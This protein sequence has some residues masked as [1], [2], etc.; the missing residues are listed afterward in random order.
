MR[1]LYVGY[2]LTDDGAPHQGMAALHLA[3]S[4]VDVV[5]ASWS[6]DPAPCWIK[7]FP[8]LQYRTFRKR[9][10]LSALRL[11][12]SLVWLVCSERWDA[13]YVQG[14][15]HTPLLLWLP[16]LRRRRTVV[17]HTQDYLE[18][19]QHRLY[20][21]CERY[22]ARR[23]DWVISN[24]VNRARFMASNYQ[25]RRMP[26]V[27]RT[28]LPTWWE[29]PGND[30]SIRRELLE[31]AGVREEDDPKLIM[32]GGPYADDRMSPQLMDAVAALPRN[33]VL[34]FTGMEGA[35]LGRCRA[36]AERC[37]MDRRAVM[38]GRMPYARLLETCAACDVGVLLYPN[39]GIGHFYQCPGRL[40][41]YLRTG[42]PFVAS[43]FPG[44]ELLALKYGLGAVADPYDAESI[45]AAIQVLA[46]IGGIDRAA[47]RERIVSLGATVFAYE[48]GAERVFERVLQIKK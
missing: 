15:Q 8:R 13:I 14:A 30:G 33:F 41:E 36:H 10:F 9:G 43:N 39:T 19:G 18:P 5:F 11:V 37:R 17:Y 32:V 25:L 22:L 38:L 1:V 28:A 20:A 27:L 3:R 24:E 42:L 4:D 2:R 48:A 26:E 46:G 23:A 29:V 34:V 40:S 47:R 7:R 21:W 6:N 16:A 12:A 44:L 35:G 31:R 45:R